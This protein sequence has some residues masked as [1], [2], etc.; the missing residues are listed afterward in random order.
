MKIDLA[1][2]REDSNVVVID[3]FV[4]EFST[5]ATAVSTSSVANGVRRIDYDSMSARLPYPL[6]RVLLVQR[7]DS[8]E[9]VAV[10]RGH[11]VRV[12]P[13]PLDAGSHRAYA[14]QWFAFAVVGII[15][16]I[17]V[18]HRDRKRGTIRP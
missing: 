5:A 13:P 7:Q 8:G 16:T 2:F 17:L 12:D 10:D 1:L 3:G 15:G 6:T 9:V 14:V 18:L 11:P 4:E